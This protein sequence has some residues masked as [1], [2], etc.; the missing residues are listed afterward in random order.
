MKEDLCDHSDF[1]G[2][3]IGSVMLDGRVVEVTVV[4]KRV[5]TQYYIGEVECVDMARGQEYT[6]TSWEVPT[7]EAFTEHETSV[8]S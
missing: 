8:V 7:G 2:E 6:D 1:T 5:D 4:K 3:T